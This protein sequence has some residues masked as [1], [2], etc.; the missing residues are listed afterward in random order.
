MSITLV[1]NGDACRMIFDGSIT[2]E[3]W[4]EQEDIIIGAMRRYTS[5][6]VDLSGIQEIDLCG[7]HLLG[8]LHSVGGKN[9]T[10]VASS[11]IVDQASKRLLASQRLASIG[12][13]ARRAEVLN[14]CRSYPRSKS[15][16]AAA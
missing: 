15:A 5:F 12:R 8:V 7:I 9:V 1:E 3:Y 16:E 14:S 6:E 4:A 11:S 13:A 2:Y 10:I